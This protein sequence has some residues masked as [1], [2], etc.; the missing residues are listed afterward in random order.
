MSAICRLSSPVGLLEAESDARGICRLTRVENAA[1]LPSDDPL[2]SRLCEEL[3][4][5]FAGTLRR[6]TVP[7][8]EHGTPFQLA[9]W[10]ALREI[11]Y[12]ESR[13]YAQIA[14]LTGHPRAARAVGSACRI[15]PLPILTPCHR[16]V[17]VAHPDAFSLG[18]EMKRFL[19][20]LE[21][22]PITKGNTP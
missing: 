19:L 5:Y 14:S 7:L 8:S 1:P 13:T 12:G 16:V 4:A 20:D 15:N 22:H 21:S 6:F 2:L 9:V 17:G 18:V 11:P 3:D 10:Q